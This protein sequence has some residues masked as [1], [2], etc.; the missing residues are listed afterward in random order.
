MPRTRQTSEAQIGKMMKIPKPVTIS[1][2]PKTKAK[3]GRPTKVK[4][5]DFENATVTPVANGYVVQSVTAGDN[6]F[7]FEDLDKA[8]DFIRT[9]LKTTV[10]Q[11]QVL[12]SI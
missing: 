1:P 11:E 10:E 6:I 2:Y 5:V 9:S 7:V 8:F 4:R 3:R 12:E